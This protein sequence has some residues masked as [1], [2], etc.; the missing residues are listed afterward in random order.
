MSEDRPTISSSRVNAVDVARHSFGTV[1]RGFDPQEVRAYLEMVARE[2]Q[3]WEQREQELRHE[4]SEAVERARHPV[5]DEATLTSALG[6]QSAQVLRHAHEEAA[7]IVAEA[8]SE[9]ARLVHEAQQ[10][11]NEVQVGAESQAAE[12]I[13]EIELAA[14]AVRQRADDDAAGL[15]EAA[16]ADGDALIARARDHGRSMIDQAQE[17]RRRVLADMAQRRRALTLQIEQFRAARDALATAV[18]SVS[19]QVDEIVADLSRADDRAR[20]AAAEVASRQPPE[21]SEAELLVEAEAAV[22]AL[23]ADAELAAIDQV[24]PEPSE[25]AEHAETPDVEATPGAG[26]HGQ[27]HVVPFDDAAEPGVVGPDPGEDT[28]EVPSTPGQRSSTMAT[29]PSGGRRP[30]RSGA[31]GNG[32]R[33]NGGA[34]PAGPDEADPAVEAQSVEELFAR[35][36]AGRGDDAAGTAGRHEGPDTVVIHDAVPASAAGT[37]SEA[38]REATVAEP[39]AKPSAR[40]APTAVAVD[41][42]AASAGGNEPAPEDEAEAEPSEEQRLLARR[43][44]L[45]DPVTAKLARRLKRALQDDQNHLLDRLRAT[46]GQWSEEALGAEEEQR[47]R[48]AEASV[49]LLREA[50]AAGIAFGSEPT[51][52]RARK[53]PAVPDDKAAR[54]AA[55]ALARTVVTLLRRRFVGSEGAPEGVDD[56]ERVGAAYREWR[57][58]R[59]ERLVGDQ[60]VHAFSAGV[61]MA[62]KKGSGIRWVLGGDGEPCADCDDNALS[63]VLAPG[64]EFPTGHFHPPAHPGCRCLVAPTPA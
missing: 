8:E 1:R 27:P 64:E 58:E 2:L 41:E 57:G 28:G 35:L 17:A 54:A 7:R 9:A 13:A 61:L 39:A 5:L 29:E 31:N 3:N 43:A 33:R 53:A 19:D 18:L 63:G 6:E 40:S 12:R 38:T 22:A 11:A 56:A 50:V 60:A 48:Y 21:P 45:L 51:G 55:D 46:N 36:R 49:A 26:E 47:A 16:R 23:E 34:G 4:V 42:G 30:D 37:A 44:E 52:G 10:R 14:G 59:I 25:H 32:G 15:L 24:G 20:S 62:A